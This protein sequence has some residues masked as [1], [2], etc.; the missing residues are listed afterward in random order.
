MAE[1]NFR[2]RLSQ[3]DYQQIADELKD[4]TG[5]AAAIVGGAMLEQR[6]REAIR[7]ENDRKS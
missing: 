1:W 3:S 4:A 5:R 6:V 2:D 7:P